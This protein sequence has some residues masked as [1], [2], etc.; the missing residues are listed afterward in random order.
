MRLIT[1]L[2]TAMAFPAICPAEDEREW[3]QL[4]DGKSLDGWTQRNGTAKYRVEEGEIVGTTVLNSPNSFLCTDKHYSDFVLEY[5]VKIDPRANSGV[6]IRSHSR[7]D[8]QQGRVHGY[9]VEIDPSARS[10]SGGIYEEGRRGWLADLKHNEAAQKAFRNGA[11]NHF[12]V[13]ARGPE[14]RTWVNQVPA[15]TLHDE[16]TSSGFIALQVHSTTSTEPL[17]VRWRNLRLKELDPSTT[18][19][20]AAEPPPGAT[21]LFNGSDLEK[22]VHQDGRKAGWKLAD[23]NAVEVV[24][25]TGNLHT[26]QKF[27]DARFHIEFR[28]PEMPTKQGQARGNSGVYL[29]DRYEIQILDSSTSLSEKAVDGN[30]SI[31]KKTAPLINVSRPPMEW[32]TYDIDF[33]APRFGTDGQKTANARVSVHHNGVLIHNNVEIPEPTGSAKKKGE[34][35]EPQ[36]LVLQEHGDRVQFRNVWAMEHRGEKE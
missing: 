4:F 2:L 1:L 27:R 15:A 35:P 8:Y 9:Q 30:G 19:S 17:E 13:E 32:Q 29:Q 12:R 18:S 10:W 28:T 23:G 5:E 14:F 20:L 6:Q 16:L 24:P 3:K 36:P 11:W 21:V 33:R 25:G 34:S 22:W 31:Y 26:R 7:P